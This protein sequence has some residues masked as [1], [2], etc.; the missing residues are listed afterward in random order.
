MVKEPSRLHSKSVLCERYE[1]KRFSL[2]TSSMYGQALG[3]LVRL[4]SAHYCTST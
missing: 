2:Q 3:L 1:M 4:G